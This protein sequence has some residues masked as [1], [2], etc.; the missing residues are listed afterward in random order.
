MMTRHEKWVH[1]R[2]LD[3]IV[4]RVSQ[5]LV[6]IMLL[7]LEQINEQYLTLKKQSESDPPDDI[8]F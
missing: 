8:S 4:D 1:E 6:S 2:N 5:L 7:G 3:E